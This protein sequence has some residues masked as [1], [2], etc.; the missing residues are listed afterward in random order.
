MLGVLYVMKRRQRPPSQHLMT[1][2]LGLSLSTLDALL[3]PDRRDIPLSYDFVRNSRALE[4]G[5]RLRDGARWRATEPCLPM[6]FGT[7]S[8]YSTAKVG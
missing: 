6:A 2:N 8:V 7:L 4:C 5:Q 1:W 3:R